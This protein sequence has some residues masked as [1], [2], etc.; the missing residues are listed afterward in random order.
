MTS[1]EARFSNSL[2]P[3]KPEGSLGRTAQNVHLDSHTAPELR[4]EYGNLYFPYAGR[5]LLFFSLVAAAFRIPTGYVAVE[6][7]NNV[8]R[9]TDMCTTSNLVEI[10]WL[11]LQQASRCAFGDGRCRLLVRQF[12]NLF[13]SLKQQQNLMKV[14]FS[15]HEWLSF[16]SAFFNSHRSGVLKAPAWLV[17][18]ETAAVSARS[19]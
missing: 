18:H 2:R 7:R 1:A 5:G 9:N 16:Y 4:W 10:S 11:I 12:F 3:R 13:A 15:W 19:V 14:K 8:V 17:P 6:G